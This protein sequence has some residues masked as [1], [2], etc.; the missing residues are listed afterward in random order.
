M[1]RLSYRCAFSVALITLALAPAVAAANAPALPSP[2]ETYGGTGWTV[3]DFDGDGRPDILTARPEVAVHGF[4][5]QVRIQLS[6]GAGRVVSFAVDGVAPGIPGIQ[7]SARDIDGDRDVDLVFTT[8]ASHEAVGVWI[9]D[10]SGRFA[11]GS[12]AAADAWPGTL[13]AAS[14]LTA[15]GIPAALAFLPRPP[16]ASLAPPSGLLHSIAGRRS[17]QYAGQAPLESNSSALPRTRAPP[18]VL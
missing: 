12:S 2:F 1:N 16:S 5:H 3:A 15:P 6:S 9:N 13:D 18:A 10:G 7:V 8:V 17:L 4:R 11:R 14:D